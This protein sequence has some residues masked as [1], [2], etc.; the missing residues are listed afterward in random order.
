M[1]LTEIATLDDVLC[2]HANELGNDFGRYRNH[3]YRVANLCLS[4]SPPHPDRLEKVAIAAA[5]HDLG[6]WTD[7]KFDSIRSPQSVWRMRI[8]PRQT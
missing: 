8:L 3:A 6:I 4:L 7:G 5:F 2:A 1:L